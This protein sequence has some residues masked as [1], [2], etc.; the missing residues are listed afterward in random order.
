LPSPY[1]LLPPPSSMKITKSAFE[2]AVAKSL[3]TGKRVGSTEVRK[4][5]ESAGVDIRFKGQVKESQIKGAF[6]ALK[7]E[8]LLKG[9]VQGAGLISFKQSVGKEAQVEAH[10]GLSE[11]QRQA[12]AKRTMRERIAEEQAKKERMGEALGFGKKEGAEPAQPGVAKTSVGAAGPHLA[13]SGGRIAG[14]AERASRP[15][16]AVTSL[17][18]GPTYRPEKGAEPPRPQKKEEPLLPDMFGPDE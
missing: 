11:E 2:K 18:G 9:K 16:K 10:P 15:A 17:G 14:Q 7:R 13:V 5:L 4:V 8:G 12:L 6:E 1:A 3:T